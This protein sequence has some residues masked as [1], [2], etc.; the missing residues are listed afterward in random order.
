M[1]TFLKAVEAGEKAKAKSCDC[2]L[3]IEHHLSINESPWCIPGFLPLHRTEFI[4]AHN[5][6]ASSPWLSDPVALASGIW[7]PWG[8]SHQS[9]V[10]DQTTL[11]TSQPGSKRE[12][13]GVQHP[14]IPSKQP[15]IMWRHPMPLPFQQHPSRPAWGPLTLDPKEN[16]KDSSSHRY[17]DGDFQWKIDRTGKS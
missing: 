15:L 5:F 2:S 7:L 9:V 8:V 4:Q 17:W 3:V 13:G 11:L 14:A 6:P 16:S 10:H 12:K 1:K